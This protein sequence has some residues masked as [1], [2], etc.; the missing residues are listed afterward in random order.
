MW[1]VVLTP[2]VIGLGLLT[3]MWFARTPKS[4]LEAG[5]VLLGLVVIIVGN[6]LINRTTTRRL[7]SMAASRPGESIC[8]FAKWFDAKTIDTWVIRAVY[9]ELQS[10]VRDVKTYGDFPLHPTDLL[11]KDLDIHPED[12]D[13]DAE[14][15]AYRTERSLEN[16]ENNPFYGRVQTVEDLVNFLNAQPRKGSL[17]S[18]TAGRGT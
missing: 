10:H 14:T 6:H 11:V 17:T 9:E 18:G 8:T 2:L 15:M 1:C 3:I 13:N 16:C 12:L 4:K 5:F 7:R